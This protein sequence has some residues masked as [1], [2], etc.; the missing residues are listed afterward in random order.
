MPGG[1]LS[2][3]RDIRPEHG[4]RHESTRV[5]RWL[6]R[7]W[8]VG[9]A[10]LFVHLAIASVGTFVNNW[11]LENTTQ[12]GQLIIHNKIANGGAFGM[13]VEIADWDN[14]GF[15]DLAVAP[16]RAASGPSADRLQGGVVIVYKGD[17]QISGTIDPD[18]S[19]PN[20]IVLWGARANDLLGTELFTGDVDGDGLEDL[21]IGAQNYDGPSGDCPNCGALYVLF[22][23]STLFDASERSI[24]L[25]SVPS[26][27]LAIYGSE[28]GGRLGI[29][30]EAGDLDGDTIEDLAIGVDQAPA[31]SLDPLFHRGEVIVVYG[32]D[33]FPSVIDFATPQG[34]SLSG[35]SRILGRDRDDHFGASLHVADLNGDDRVELIVGSALERLSASIGA[36]GGVF[37]HGSFRG[38][39]GPQNT[40]DGAG[41]ATIL[42]SQPGLP[43]LPSVVDLNDLPPGM[44]NAVTYIYGSGDLEVCA[45]EITSGDFNGDGQIDLALGAIR[46]RNPNFDPA[47]GKAYAIYWRS[48]LEGVEIDLGNIVDGV[49]PPGVEISEMYGLSSSDIL[50]DTL[51][52]GDFNHDGFSDLAIGIPHGQANGKHHAGVVA[53]VYGCPNRWPALWAPQD[54]V[55]PPNLQLSYVLG[56]RSG[57]LLSYSMEALDYNN[58]GFADLFP[59]AMTADGVGDA[60]S[61]A[62]DAYIVGGYEMSQTT[63]E[64]DA[65]EPTFGPAGVAT[66]V[67]ITGQGFTTHAD[68]TVRVDGHDVADFEVVNSRRL[69]LDMPS[70]SMQGEVDVE[71]VTRYGSVT[72]SPAFTILGEEVF[73]RG[74]AEPN[75]SINISD[76]ITIL[77][78]LFVAPNFDCDDAGDAN[79]DGSLNLADALY[80]LNHLFQSAPPP[81]PPYPLLGL[82]PT[83]DSLGCNT[84]HGP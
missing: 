35:V 1:C 75:L 41:E 82:D 78:H 72:L 10:L 18:S 26:D 8:T 67:E 21:I 59:N 70:I 79:D 61:S 76:P 57:D 43:R 23:K 48:G 44:E 47:A 81:K 4:P 71:V 53:I 6:C 29:W 37:A 17:G 28:P 33:N 34:S 73:L 14:D 74:D 2:T 11:D 50:G 7:A 65:V 25:T 45:E 69:Q 27:V 77:N 64:L 52:A 54:P 62:G 66:P 9:L 55:P 46:G 13:P 24:D 20:S 36:E 83:P 15:P 51:S 5:S 63:L 22:G 42:F 84:P 3:K 12:P 30:M 80:L 39:N 60:F 31:D 68:M 19:P 49:A 16:M 38:G 56:A 58:D 40:R 32:R